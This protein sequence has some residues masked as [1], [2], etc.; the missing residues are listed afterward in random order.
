[1][2]AYRTSDGDISLNGKH[3]ISV[4][5]PWNKVEAMLRALQHGGEDEM[6]NTEVYRRFVS[7]LQDHLEATECL[8]ASSM[9]NYEGPIGVVGPLR[10]Q[11]GQPIDPEE[12]TNIQLPRREAWALVRGDKHVSRSLG[13]VLETLLV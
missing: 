5:L 1:M 12:S 3:R 9:P 10:P 2:S 11:D 7:V 4:H 13:D 6:C 8:I